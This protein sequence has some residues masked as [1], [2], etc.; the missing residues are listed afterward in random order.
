MGLIETTSNAFCTLAKK[1]HDR[2]GSFVCENRDGEGMR[3]D[4]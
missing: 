2:S 3:E 4:I 1:G